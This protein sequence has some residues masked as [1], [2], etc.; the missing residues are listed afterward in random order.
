MS[1][2]F[3]D[4]LGLSSACCEECERVAFSKAPQSGNVACTAVVLRG[5]HTQ[6]GNLGE[7][8]SYARPC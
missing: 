5:G 3:T 2:F 1:S 7:I 6:I 4:R 8:L